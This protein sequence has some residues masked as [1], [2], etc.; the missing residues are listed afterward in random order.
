MIY[1]LELEINFEEFIKKKKEKV[2]KI[3]THHS[4]EILKYKIKT[5]SGFREFSQVNLVHCEENTFCMPQYHKEAERVN[6]FLRLF[7]QLT[8]VCVYICVYIKDNNRKQK[9]HSRRCFCVSES[10]KFCLWLTRD[11][12]EKLSTVV[13]KNGRWWNVTIRVNHQ[14]RVRD[15]EDY[16]AL[17]NA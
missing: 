11:F 4:V 16:I 15:L 10:I 3:F 17:H 13:D 2:L 6:R 8:H 1:G 7:Y 9:K 5:Y 12:G 14:S